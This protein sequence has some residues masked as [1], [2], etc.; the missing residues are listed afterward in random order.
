M[1]RT[2]KYVLAAVSAGALAGSAASTAFAGRPA[3][4]QP[5]SVGGNLTVGG[6]AKF[7]GNVNVAKKPLYMHGGGQVWTS[8]TDHGT[9]TVANGATIQKGGLKVSSGGIATDTLVVDTSMKAAD[10]EITGNLSAGPAQFTGPVSG[11]SFTAAGSG[12]T[13]GSLTL[14]N[15]SNN[16]TLTNTGNSTISTTGNIS[17][18]NLTA[19][20]TFSAANLSTNGSV[21]AGS[22]VDNGTLQAQ[23]IATAGAVQ[24]QS[25][26]ATGTVQGNA[27]NAGSMTVTNAVNANTANLT[28][29]KVTGAIDF[30]NATVTGLTLG[31]LGGSVSTLT[32]GATSANTPPLSVSENGQ[33]A[34]VGVNGSGAVTVN[35]L[36]VGTALQVGGAG[37]VTGNLTVG[38]SL[39]LNN[40]LSLPGNTTTTGLLASEIT[41]TLVSSNPGPLSINSSALTINAPTTALNTVTLAGGSN[42]ALSTGSSV[43]SHIIANGDTDVSGTLTVPISGG[44]LYSAS[45]TFTQTYSST[46]VVVVTPV[47]PSATDVGPIR[48]WVTPHAGSFTIT[49]GGSPS[50]PNVTFDYVVIGQ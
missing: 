10:A 17:A 43:A 38:G 37:T 36:N 41:G 32:V 14:S 35:N 33:T 22:V 29:L 3:A 5:L 7:N 31:N 44:P 30:T 16:V 24:A 23:A 9:M 8:F 1:T 46:P 6:I 2:W 48:Y 34:Q 15:G 39:T 18:A 12:T 19:T 40:G 20:G 49:V 13:G 45:Y 26:T 21:T 28:N 4:P 42:L 11:T 47:S 27:V 50:V 25:V